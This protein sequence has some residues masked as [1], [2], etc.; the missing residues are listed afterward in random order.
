MSVIKEMATLRISIIDFSMFLL[1]SETY[2]VEIRIVI[3]REIRNGVCERP[4]PNVVA[5][6]YFLKTVLLP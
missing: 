3:L 1:T 6:L 4:Y 2:K 5:I